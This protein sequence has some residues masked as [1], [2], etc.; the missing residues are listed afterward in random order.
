MKRLSGITA[1]V[2]GLL[3]WIAIPIG[4]Q[5]QGRYP[6]RFA[7]NAVNGGYGPVWLLKDGKFLEKNGID[8]EFT[9]IEGDQKS[10]QALVGG[11]MDIV[12]LSGAA[13]I[14]ANLAG[15]DSV[16]VAGHVNTMPYSFVT[17]AEVKEPKDL[18]GK[19]AGVSSFG[20]TSDT[21]V[22]FAL[23]RLG[24]TPEKDVAVIVIGG[25]STRFAAMKAG[26]IQGT[27]ISPPWTL[28]AR[29]LGYNLLADLSALGLEYPHSLIASRKSFIKEKPEVV[30]AFVRAWVESIAYFKQNP[31]QGVEILGK[32]MKLND[33]E[34]LRESYEGFVKLIPNKPYI[35]EK[36]FQT[37]LDLIA[38]KNP[39][40]A[41]AKPEQFMDL[42][43]VREIDRS[44]AIDKLYGR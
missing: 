27:V 32:Y 41:A 38:G 36:A 29:K 13:L 22:R 24:L 25:E 16:S 11:S 12:T 37:L 17:T 34:A 43:F 6:L 10:I 18:K 8:V 5:A 39:K 23:Q 2:L 21:A 42:S 44:G 15:A 33:A 26:G 3:L 30:R 31:T 20:S 19:K 7:W 9:F 14:N 35:T 28:T 1:I 4:S 40:A